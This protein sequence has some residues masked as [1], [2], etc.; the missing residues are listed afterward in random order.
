MVMQ[1]E[2]FEC[3]LLRRRSSFR[4]QGLVLGG[5]VAVT[6][7]YDLRQ[8]GRKN[9]NMRLANNYPVPKRLDQVLSDKSK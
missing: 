7:L 5:K 3:A 9:I 6:E 1:H 8:T 2:W 4:T